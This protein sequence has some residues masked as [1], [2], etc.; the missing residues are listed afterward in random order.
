[1]EED[2]YHCLKHFSVLTV[3]LNLGKY[4]QWEKREMSW[5][6]KEG[7]GMYREYELCGVILWGKYFTP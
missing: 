1:M 3:L 4:T 6:G 2:H 5:Q 7:G